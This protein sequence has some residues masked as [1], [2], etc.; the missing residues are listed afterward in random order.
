MGT[1]G[2]RAS[3]AS[4]ELIADSIELVVERPHVRRRD[5]AER[6]RQDDP[7]HGHGA[8]PA[9]HPQPDALRRLDH[10]GPLPRRAD[11]HPGG[12]RGRRRPRRRSHH[13]RRADRDRGRGLARRRRLR[14]SVHRQHDGDGLRGPGHLAR[15][16]SMG[17]GGRRAQGR[18]GRAGRRAG[19]GRAQARAAPERRSSPATA[20]RTRSPAI[21]CSGGSTNGVLH[22]LAIAREMGIE[23]SIDDFDEISERTPLL[24]DLKPGGQYVAPDL[25]AAGG[26]PLVMQRLQEAGLLH[27]DAITVTGQTVGEIAADGARDRGPGGRPPARR[28]DQGDRRAGHPARQPGPRRLR[29]QAGRLRAPPPDRP[30]AGVRV[31]GGRDGRRHRQRGSTPAT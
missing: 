14:R 4:R 20:S 1:P 12:V 21:A 24:C 7:R 15:R 25:Y 10:A 2:M 30:G 18:R 23:L 26:V 22:L 9:R 5:R 13:R 8:V 27:E 19:H 29:G 6:L 28:P 17:S 31:R 3:L 16:L 11:H